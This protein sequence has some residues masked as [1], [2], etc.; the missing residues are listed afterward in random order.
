MKIYQTILNTPQYI[1][2]MQLFCKKHG[3]APGYYAEM[4]TRSL[5][6]KKDN[7]KDM[8]FQ[9]LTDSYLLGTLNKGEEIAGFEETL[10][11][12][13]VLAEK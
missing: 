5:F 6:Q 11:K 9:S 8:I 7:L 13:K 2:D 10:Q 3:V 12:L 1:L 4:F